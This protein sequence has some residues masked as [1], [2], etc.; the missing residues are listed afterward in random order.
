M[1]NFFLEHSNLTDKQTTFKKYLPTEKNKDILDQRYLTPQETAN[2]LS[3]KLSLLSNWR[4]CGKG[5]VYVKLG[6]GRCALV[7]YP[8]LGVGG[9]LDYM[10]LNIQK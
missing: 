9:I 6:S 1:H 2:M 8:L 3:I 7:R 4:V 10:N 5:P